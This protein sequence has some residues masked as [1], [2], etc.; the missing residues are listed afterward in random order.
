MNTV[1]LLNDPAPNPAEL[2][3]RWNGHGMPSQR[4]AT[5]EDLDVVAGYLG[6]W[7]AVV[8]A[9]T[10]TERVQHL[11]RMLGE[12]TAAPSITDH[13]GSGW[14]LHFRDPEAGFGLTLAGATTAAAA[15]FLTARGIHR[16]GRC[17]LAECEQAFIDF[18]RPGTQRY[19]SR[20][21]AN[22]DAVR[23]HRARRISA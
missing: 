21:C 14:H 18:S 9:G 3:S 16:L 7:R 4:P 19:C 15:Q 10:E 22:R 1:E 23:R 11:N 20:A 2:E 12:Y 5:E 6:L 8:D 13:D 17:H